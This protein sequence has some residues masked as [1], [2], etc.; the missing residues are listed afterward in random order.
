MLVASWTQT[1]SY[2]NVSI[3]AVLENGTSINAYLVNQIGPG[4][5]VANQIAATSISPATLVETDTLF[6]GLSLGGGTYYLVLAAPGSANVAGWYG[7]NSPTV[8]TDT[9]VTGNLDVF[10]S[11]QNGSPNDAY[12]PASTFFLAGTS[13]LLTVTGDSGSPVPEPSSFILV[14]LAGA[15]LFC[16]KSRLT[17]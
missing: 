3:S 11:D 14:G 4:T 2:S 9:G 15:F 13:L 1:G 5:T 8:T 10:V 16:A 6:S 12:A 7:T 17:R